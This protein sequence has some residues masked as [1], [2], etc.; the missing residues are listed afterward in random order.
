MLLSAHLM[1][2]V[3]Q[4]STFLVKNHLTIRNIALNDAIVCGVKFL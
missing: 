1:C 4:N 3:V 2:I